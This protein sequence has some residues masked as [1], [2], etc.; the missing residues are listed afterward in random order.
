MIAP[1]KLARTF[2]NNEKREDFLFREAIICHSFSTGL[3]TFASYRLRNAMRQFSF[4]FVA[5]LVF[6]SSFQLLSAQ[7]NQ[8][9]VGLHR[10]NAGVHMFRNCTV[11]ISPDKKIEDGVLII[12]DG[13]I[14]HAG[15][16]IAKP[17][18]AVEHD[19]KGA[20]IYPGFIESYTSVGLPE[21]KK[22]TSGGNPQYHSNK[23]GSYYWNQAVNSE[24][25]AATKVNVPN[26]KADA[27]RNGG[28]TSLHVVPKDGIF[29]G[30]SCVVNLKNDKRSN[31]ILHTG[32]TS[33]ISFDKG[34]SNQVYPRSIMG[35]IALINQVLSE[36]AWY[37][38]ARPEWLN[39]SREDE[40]KED[41]SLQA[42]YKFRDG[43]RPW[44]FDMGNANNVLRG[45][46]IASAN[47]LNAIYRTN[48]RD[49]HHLD[50]I[51]SKKLNL[52]I[53][54]HFPESP[55]LED[56]ADVNS[57]TLRQLREW[58]LRPANPALL[59]GKGLKVA[60]T[61]HDLD[62]A[63]QALGKIRQAIRCGL[64][65]R[66]A[67][68]A[69]TTTPAD[70][71]GIDSLVGS[72]EKG[73][74]ANFFVASGNIFENDFEIKETWVEGNRFVVVEDEIED[75]RGEYLLHI[76]TSSITLKISGK[77]NASSASLFIGSD[78]TEVKGK[79]SVNDGQVVM[80][81]K[82]VD[83]LNFVGFKLAGLRRDKDLFGT[84]TDGDGNQ[85]VWSASFKNGL[86][87]KKKKERAEDEWKQVSNITY[88]NR[89]YGWEKLPASEAVLIKNATVWTN[90][91]E[92]VVE[93]CDVLIKDGLIAG[94][95]RGLT[96]GGA[97]EID[98]K[99]KHV[100]PGIIDEHSH[101]AIQGGVNEGSHNVS[102]EV[103]IADVINPEDVNIYRQLA[104]GVTTSQLLH[105]SANP[106]GGQSAIIKLRWGRSA[107]EMKFAEAPGFIKFALGE[108][109]KQ[110]NWGDKF[111]SRYPQS[112]TGVQQVYID[113][114]AAA[115]KYKSDWTAFADG[116][117]G[118]GPRPDLQ[119]DCLVEILDGKRHIT[120]HSYRQSEI[121]MLMKTSE[122]MG[123][124]VN[125]FTHILEG[126]KVAD[127]MKEYGVHA[128]TF[129]D[130]WAYKYE[131]IDA[132]PHNASLLNEVG[133]NTMINSDDREMARRLNQEAAKAIKYGGA[134]EEDALKMV[135]LNP[136]KALHIDKYVGSIA[137][138]KHAD[139]VIWDD[140]PLSVYAKV[141][142]T[143]VDGICYYDSERD[144]KLREAIKKEKSELIAKIGSGGKGS[145]KPGRNKSEN[146]ECETITDY[147]LT[148]E[149]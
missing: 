58:E 1:D 22:R 109:V 141:E 60:F 126:Y 51:A 135:T 30:T 102:A 55:N 23:K 6:S 44:L 40:V 134:S 69:L 75:I 52:I 117:T 34:S 103:S 146:Y 18:D 77:S 114:F 57:V 124:K 41:L 130:W 43:G 31:L 21:V 98:A 25:D 123:F 3:I 32:T 108:N 19:L 17:T 96:G 48:G 149:E 87:D 107:E 39:G 138:K 50:Q 122:Q 119:M 132:I 54:L 12:R 136:A 128:S 104:G 27:F 143:F 68:A 85:V 4:L 7:S 8:P 147:E 100:T 36:S 63:G 101:M 97:K 72:L 49:F 140:H 64:K 95:G 37:K 144:K 24:F 84:G 15:K 125:T 20:W 131:V 142:K 133:V 82:P 38:Q 35:A 28:F 13:K 148:E 10:Y 89:G 56:P 93:G 76:D 91:E 129:S 116:G 90:T 139:I 78:T 42:T 16:R 127:K 70:F 86:D 66:D 2:K 137:P 71:L 80:G 88:P 74:F 110:S 113:A 26:D 111:R 121:N 105:G 29:R 33:G 11:V 61:T 99:G 9:A 65:E 53:P 115:K 79:I 62:N 145:Q 106:I 81:F 120:C 83:S 118:A 92:G 45:E 94:V 112:R 73:K 46:I 5:F 67:L 47:K 14:E 59:V